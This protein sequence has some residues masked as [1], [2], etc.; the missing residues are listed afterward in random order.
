MGFL[1]DLRRSRILSRNLLDG[2]AWQDIVEQHPIVRRLTPE[3][4][5]R[6]RELT[7]LFLHEKSFQA[8]RGF[9]LDPFMCQVI[10][11]Q[12]CLPVLELGLD[13]YRNWKW[14]L[15][16]PEPDTSQRSWVDDASVVHERDGE[17]DGDAPAYGY[18]SVRL[19]WSSVEE[20]GWGHGD[21][22]VIH[23]AAHIL[24]EL[25]GTLDGCPAL[26]EGLRS[27][28]WHSVFSAALEDMQRKVTSRKRTRIRIDEY[29]AESD[30]E[31]FAVAS[32]Y[33]FE[34]PR[35]LHGEYPDVYRL[36]AAFYRQDPLGRGVPPRPL[37]SSGA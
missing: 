25:D 23:E 2:D 16:V 13:W 17:W 6:L 27:D 30:S 18:G 26:D 3:Q 8:S 21:N 37:S 10:A 11:A 33:F 32:E 7:T 22:V 9:T 1:K 36:L 35:L 28:E 12:A 14:V 29:A 5:A 34:R 20:A 15:V 19:A 24:D 31:F 4:L